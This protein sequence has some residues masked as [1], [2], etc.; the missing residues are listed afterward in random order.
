MNIIFLRE[1]INK[2]I[3]MLINSLNEI[4]SHSGI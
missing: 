1:T 4:S 3:L 2:L